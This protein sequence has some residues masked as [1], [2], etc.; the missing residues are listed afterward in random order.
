MLMRRTRSAASAARLERPPVGSG[1]PSS[2]LGSPRFCSAGL[3]ASS[4][5]W[6]R[7]AI[8]LIARAIA[9]IASGCRLR[10]AATASIGD[11]SSRLESGPC[12]SGSNAGGAVW[13]W[14]AQLAGGLQRRRSSIPRTKSRFRSSTGRAHPRRGAQPPTARILGATAPQTDRRSMANHAGFPTHG[15]RGPLLRRLLR[16][17][18]QPHHTA[19]STRSFV[20]TCSYRPD[21]PELH[22]H[23]GDMPR[24]GHLCLRRTGPG[25]R[26]TTS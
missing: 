9:L 8:A 21:S 13:T 10:A 15:E 24:S 14:L 1:P 18:R 16:T 5:S 3:F 19:S 17:S 11:Q 12:W 23:L 25:G 20:V 6:R 26:M 22:E 2:L 7:R 4:R